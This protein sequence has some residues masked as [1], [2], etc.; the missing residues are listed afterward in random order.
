MA[1]L[2]NECGLEDEQAKSVVKA[3]AKRL[4]PNI[5]INY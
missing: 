4:I 3:I 2:I 5:T 1:D